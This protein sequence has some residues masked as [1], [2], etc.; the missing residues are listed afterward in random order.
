MVLAKYP[1]WPQRLQA[2]LLC[3]CSGVKELL[4]W[5]WHYALGAGGPS[6]LT[7]LLT[8]SFS[9]PMWWSEPEPLLV[10][11]FMLKARFHLKWKHC[12]EITMIHRVCVLRFLPSRWKTSSEHPSL[13]GALLLNNPQQF[14]PYRPWEWYIQ[15]TIVHHSKTS[16]EIMDHPCLSPSSTKHLSNWTP[17]P[18]RCYSDHLRTATTASL[19]DLYYTN[20]SNRDYMNLTP[21][22]LSTSALVLGKLTTT[23]QAGR[24]PSHKCA[25]TGMALKQVK[26]SNKINRKQLYLM[27]V[28][29]SNKE[30]GWLESYHLPPKYWSGPEKSQELKPK[31]LIL[32]IS[33]GGR[34]H[35]YTWF[36][37]YFKFIRM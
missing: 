14:R 36:N 28:A 8:V 19:F 2:T 4:G 16:L 13:S 11:F 21:P 22:F 31:T 15:R 24:L 3:L 30:G 7:S 6:S 27:S 9:S 20:S 5:N 17:Q 37:I 29:D 18:W 10:T 34:F 23:D 33:V 1:P 35:F 25:G 12:E 32:K 26:N